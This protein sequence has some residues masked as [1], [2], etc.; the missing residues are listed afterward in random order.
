MMDLHQAARR[1][2][3]C[4][5]LTNL[6]EGCTAEDVDT[7]C[8]RADTPHGP[9]AAVCIWP[10]FIDQ[11]RLRLATR[12]IRIATVVNFPSG[13]DAIDDVVAL[14]EQAIRDGADEIDTVIPYPLLLEGHPNEV[15]ASVARVKEAAGEKQVKAIL[16]TGILAEE[17]LI[18]TAARAAIDGGADFIKTSTGK[19]PVNATL[20]GAR[21]ML[22]AIRDSGEDVGFKPAGGV[23]S[24]ADAAAYISLAD[25]ILGEGWADATRFRIGASGVLDALL[26]TL[27]GRTAAESSGY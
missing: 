13:M 11:A 12:G 24:T 9:T 20:N 14:T 23:K 19:V 7:L 22:E 3:A 10:H 27:D 16:E 18:R 1:A 8:D 21:I 17:D 4:L 15:T 6:N 2:I 5:D 26:A 25:E